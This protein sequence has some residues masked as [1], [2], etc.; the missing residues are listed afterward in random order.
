MPVMSPRS[1]LDT[2]EN[3]TEPVDVALPAGRRVRRFRL[4][5]VEGSAA[6]QAWTSSGDTCSI[7]SHP[8]ND[9]HVEDKA[10][11][12]FHC[13]VRVQGKGVVVRD[14]QSRNGTSVDGVDVV[15]AWLRPGSLIRLGRTALQIQMASE[16]NAL[17]LSERTSFG[18]LV[19]GSVVMRSTFALLERAAASDATIL[20]EGE[21]GT[22]KEG[23]AE[24]I[25]NESARRE[26]PFLVVDCS[27]LPAN[28]LESE[29]FGHEKGAF[30]GA[31]GRRKGAF[32]EAHG[33]TI[34]LD[35][36]GELGA[37][38]QPK[39]LRVLENREVK[40]VGANLARPV[41]VRVIAATN[42]D[43]RAEVNAGRFRSD[44]YFRLAVVK[45]GM[46]PLRQ[47]ADDV[48]LLIDS[49]VRSLGPEAA[50]AAPKIL[51]PA[52]IAG[53]THSAWPGNVRELRN[54][55]QRCLV[56]QQPMPVSE[57]GVFDGD[58]DD[59]VDAT[60][61]FSQ[62]RR[63]AI[64]AFERRYLETLLEQHGGNVAR[65]AQASGVHKVHLYRLLRRHT[66]LGE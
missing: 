62:A 53:L 15:E 24:S 30:T 44:V 60:V 3:G 21:T 64:N 23:A 47:R 41:D 32:E 14:L 18:S 57:H 66:L 26:A 34:F 51:T 59:Q 2:N 49:I 9:L 4:V 22:G 43:L 5:F 39:L 29:L 58:D 48:P 13:E 35:E 42:R 25:H 37:D 36:V 28:L 63:Q 33:G 55:L 1:E 7:G 19:G 56:L 50:A 16:T 65:A 46:P 8:S 11:S 38:L 40:P 17:P 27:A 45:I 12:R 54:W 61:P 52:T 20:L 6:G 10:V 31:A